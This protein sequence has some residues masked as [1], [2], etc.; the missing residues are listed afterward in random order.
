M[1][2]RAGAESSVRGGVP[3][4]AAWCCAVVGWVVSPE[5]YGPWTAAASRRKE[6]GRVGAAYRGPVGR[7]RG[8]GAADRAPGAEVP[9][10]AERPE[11]PLP[12]AVPRASCTLYTTGVRL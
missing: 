10:R 4:F 11:A 6:G 2:R 12:L 3:R 5:G 1:A 7:C 8:A 9:G